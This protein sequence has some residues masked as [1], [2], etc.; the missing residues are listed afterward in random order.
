M[1]PAELMLV[2]HSHSNFNKIINT[3]GS[4]KDIL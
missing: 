1:D 3:T 2:S 4:N